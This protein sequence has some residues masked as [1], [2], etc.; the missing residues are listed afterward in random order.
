[1]EYHITTDTHLTEALIACGQEMSYT[2]DGKTVYF[3]FPQS[4]ILLDLIERFRKGTLH[5]GLLD[6][7]SE[8]VYIVNRI[9]KGKI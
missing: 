7:H 3:H 6:K 4:A 1:M 2:R 5:D 8:A 9:L